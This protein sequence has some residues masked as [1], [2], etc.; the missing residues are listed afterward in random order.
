MASA[1]SS[2][3][4]PP[5]TKRAK[6]TDFDSEIAPKLAKTQYECSLAISNDSRNPSGKQFNRIKVPVKFFSLC[7]T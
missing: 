7:H 4:P 2:E 5:A 3:S 6:L 1:P